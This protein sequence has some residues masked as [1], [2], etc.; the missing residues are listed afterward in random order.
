M[1]FQSHEI[2]ILTSSYGKQDI[3]IDSDLIRSGII[4]DG[5]KI[6]IWYARIHKYPIKKVL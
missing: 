1:L 5:A 6:V 4:R 3:L 2:L